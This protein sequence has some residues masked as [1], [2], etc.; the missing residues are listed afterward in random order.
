MKTFK[1]IFECVPVGLQPGEKH[2][3]MQSP[4]YPFMQVDNLGVRYVDETIEEF[5]PFG[6]S[7]PEKIQYHIMENGAKKIK[8]TKSR[9]SCI[10]GA[11]HATEYS[12]MGKGLIH[13]DHNPYNFRPDNI[14]PMSKAGPTWKVKQFQ[15]IL[16]SIEIML[17]KDGDKG[18]RPE[19]WKEIGIPEAILK[20]YNKEKKIPV[21]KR[22]SRYIKKKEG[23]PRIYHQATME[24]LKNRTP[25]RIQEMLDSGMKN[26]DVAVACGLTPSYLSILKKKANIK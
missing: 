21:L 17:E 9:D 7:H 11:W 12:G 14:I 2:H 19:Y 18:L 4:E 1:N 24:E 25:E 23:D 15:F 22:P 5:A 20:Y 10:Y 13:F 26:K 8:W 3:M 16:D 6:Y